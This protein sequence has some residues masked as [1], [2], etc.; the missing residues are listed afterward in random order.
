MK[1]CT[2]VCLQCC[3]EF[4][5]TEKTSHIRKCCSTQCSVKLKKAIKTKLENESRFL[6][7]ALRDYLGKESIYK[8]RLDDNHQV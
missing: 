7:D 4:E 3:S 8:S 6:I 1:K 5:C 2:K